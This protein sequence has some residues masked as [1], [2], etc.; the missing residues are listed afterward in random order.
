MLM[1]RVRIGQHL[2]TYRLATALCLLS[3]HHPRSPSLRIAHDGFNVGTVIH[4]LL[5]EL[6]GVPGTSGI[7]CLI[8]RG[9]PPVP[10]IPRSNVDADR[11]RRV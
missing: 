3:S 9:R 8:G 5:Q 7:G 10:F 11:V 4:P 6:G 2:L 1:G